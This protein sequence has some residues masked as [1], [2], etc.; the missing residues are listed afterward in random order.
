MQ[1]SQHSPFCDKT[2]VYKLGMNHREN[3]H[4]TPKPHMLAALKNFT[5]DPKHCYKDISPKILDKIQLCLCWYPLHGADTHKQ[6]FVL[7]TQPNPII[8]QDHSE[9][10]NFSMIPFP[11][12]L[13]GGHHMNNEINICLIPESFSHPPEIQP[14][15]PIKQGG[16]IK[17][18]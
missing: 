13:V 8:W 17:A 6:R 11:R 9:T 10:C 7:F 1:E 18:R 14:A 5:S 2:S 12:S 3:I 15:Y 4:S 16:F